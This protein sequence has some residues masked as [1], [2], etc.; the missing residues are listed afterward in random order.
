[1]TQ[2]SKNL[3]FG[4]YTV[5]T[6]SL[7]KELFPKAGI[8]KQDLI[9]YSEDI[10][11][12]MLPHLRA[13]PLS[14]ERYPDGVQSEGFFQ[15]NTPDYVPDWIRTRQLQKEGGTVEHTLVDNK[16]TLVYLANQAC[17]TIHTGLSRVCEP[18]HPVEMVIDLDPPNE[19][20][21]PVQKVAGLLRDVLEEEFDL[22]CF[23]KFTG[24]R[25]LHV[26]VP[27]QG[28][29][30]FETVRMFADDLTELL[31]KR[32]PD[33][34]TTAQRKDKRGK[35]VFLDINRN[36]YGQTAVV[37]YAVRS[38]KNAP[39]AC[40]VEWDEA[41][42]KGADPKQFTLKNIKK[43]LDQKGDVWSSIRRHAA[44]LAPRR[45]TLHLHG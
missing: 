2:D 37:P 44:I 24:S 30:S 31:V 43:R 1:M 34:V 16:A 41:L 25:G 17:I 6:S 3:H 18:K 33:L 40:P 10:S 11:G 21:K 36:A 19:N 9:Q 38:K 35:R 29:E 20:F 27:L 15:K 7:S 39:V 22:T 5:E 14:F 28:T 4:P 32:H 42:A 8:T 13:R 45:D 23:A 26:V 12:F